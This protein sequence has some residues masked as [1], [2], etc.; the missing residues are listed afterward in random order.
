MGEK[1]KDKK[2]KKK[3]KED[4]KKEKKDK[5]KK[6][7]KKDKEKK[8]KKKDRD[9][10]DDDEPNTLPPLHPL[11]EDEINL[12]AAI[13]RSEYGVAFDSDPEL[14]KLR[15]IAIAVKEPSREELWVE[16]VSGRHVYVLTLNPETGIATE[17]LVEFYAKSAALVSQEDLPK[18]TQPM[19]CP[20]DLDLAERMV[21][22]SYEIASVL[23][24][25]YG[26]SA[27]ELKNS[28][29]CDPW[30]LHLADDDTKL[31]IGTKDDTPRR[32]IQAFL[33]QRQY[34]N[35]EAKQD[36]AYAHPIDLLPL[37]DLNSQSVGIERRQRESSYVP[38]IPQEAVNYHRDL[39]GTNS[40]LQTVWRS[41]VLKTL[42][43][44]QPD[45]PSFTVTDQHVEW[46]GWT[47][48]VS[49]NY[50]EG[51]VLH[52]IQYEDRSILQRAS[53]VEMAVPYA[54]PYPPHHRKC[55]FDVG[56]YGLGYCATSLELGC[57]CVGSIYY[58]DAM[59]CNAA[60][61]P[62]KKKKVVCMHEEDT[63]ILWKHVEYRN[64]WNES[65]R[66]RE[67][68][69]S[70]IAT[71]V[72]YE[73]LF[74]WRFKL[75]G[76]I[77][78]EIKLSGELSTNL[79]SEK[80]SETGQPTHGV[81]VAPGVNA[82]IHQHMFCARLDVAVDGQLNTVSEVD[83]ITQA[84]DKK[85]NPFGNCFI[86][87]E[88]VLETESEAIRQC[89]ASK[90]RV[91]KISSDEKTNPINGKPTAYKL[92]PYSKGPAQP[93]LMVDPS[94]EVAKKAAFATANLW[95]TP[96]SENERFPAG[97]HTPQ[98]S[99][100]DGLADW[101][102]KDRSLVDCEEGLVVWHS[103][104]VVHV[105]RVEDFP[106]MPCEVTGFTLKPDNFFGGNP[107]I[108]VPPGINESSQSAGDCCA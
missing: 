25:R 43:I 26:I 33:Y 53:L 89:D 39:L 68:V 3:E 1:D 97:E 93:T 91:W 5:D 38:S 86:P 17:H 36:C 52:N 55:A 101:T 50:R 40:Y 71:V 70:F 30:S 44:T 8:T 46:Q 23:K 76:T 27:E 21:L 108:D 88:T 42:N 20:D 79:L 45:G 102:K 34:G 66:S 54:D 94:C 15:F 51:L 67:L 35:L 64:G 62:V 100:S 29:V 57:D 56:D 61:E 2:A 104:G 14:K 96:Y 16:E 75:D 22:G 98:G 32:L 19:L 107:A 80:E 49:F 82:Q 63:G 92:I 37:V 28:I 11:T 69:V 59:L 85:T 65:R 87:M 90:A 47:F 78:F 31:L 74:Y 77:D 9:G 48:D 4:K 7:K 10:D 95:V 106:V 84:V 41:S 6:D 72:N 13:I 24:D 58:F 103:F 12:A 73:Y 60:G 18:G 99:G 83:I 105:P 81:L